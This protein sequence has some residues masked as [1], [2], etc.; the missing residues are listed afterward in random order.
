[1]SMIQRQITS[2]ALKF[3]DLL[4]MIVSFLVASL[5]VMVKL[6]PVS[7]VRFLSIRI[8]LQNLLI[9]FALL[10][11]WNVVFRMIGLYDSKRLSSRLAELTEVIKA[12]SLGTLVIAIT[13]FLLK[14]R[15]ITPG[16]IIIF[17]LFTTT[18]AI[19]GRLALRTWLRYI[20]ARGRNSRNML[21]VGANRRAFDFAKAIQ[22]RP[23]LGYRIIGFA[24]Q[25]WQGLHKIRE[26]GFS[27]IC[28][29]T[30][31]PAFIRHN[32]VD[33]V[34]MALPIRSFHVD[35]CGIAM[36][37]QEQGIIFHLLSDIFNLKKALPEAE[38]VDEAGLIAHYTS[39]I[40]GWPRLAKRI[41]DF[42]I[43]L[44]LL[45]LL[46]PLLVTVGILV[47]LTSPGPVLFVQKRIGLNKR[48][49]NIHKFRTMIVNAEDK[50]QEIEHL[51]EVSGPV[52]KIKNDPRLTPIGRFLRK[53]SIDEL[54]QL[55]NVLRG[56]M[57]LV[58]P[59]PLQVRDYELFTECCEDWQRCRFSV[60]P[61]ITCLW[62]INGRSL[63]PFEK[64][65]ELDLQYV[66][67]WSFWL[68]LKILAQTVPVVLKGSG[69]A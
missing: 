16:F 23:E 15:M 43:A 55:F 3:F 2:D 38:E 39:A 24:D 54:P 19:G 66:R 8:K 17:W 42:T 31:L 60:P 49:F 53:T 62:Q 63:L 68:D 14:L 10:W 45:I 26:Y 18:V 65:M 69:A 36:L 61:G 56:D 47:K 9:F 57:S 11:A 12:T 32:V 50:L 67:K 20:R 29:L 51:N 28:G 59:R 33:E 7:F 22:S 13:A 41:L 5:P 46:V 6:A 52:F 35:A 48:T 58:G 37:C 25:E 27:L 40:T 44:A 21:I 64:W 30:S 1:M 34:V 4:L